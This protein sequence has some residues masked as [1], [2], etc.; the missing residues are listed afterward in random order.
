MDHPN[1]L[2]LEQGDDLADDFPAKP[3]RVW[4][5]GAGSSASI[6]RGILAGRKQGFGESAGAHSGAGPP[7]RGRL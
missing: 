4:I 7:Q 6:Q 1:A 3:A 2:S 5:T